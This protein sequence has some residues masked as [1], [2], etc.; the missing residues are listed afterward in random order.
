MLIGRSFIQPR[1][2]WLLRQLWCPLTHQLRFVMENN[3]VIWLFREYLATFK[4]TVAMHEV[5]LQRIA[6]HSKLRDDVNFRVFLEYTEDVSLFYWCQTTCI[7]NV[8]KPGHVHIYK[9]CIFG[10]ML[11]SWFSAKGK[12]VKKLVNFQYLVSI[13]IFYCHFNYV[14]IVQLLVYFF[15][16][17]QILC[18]ELGLELVAYLSG[19]PDPSS[20]LVVYLTQVV[21]W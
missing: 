20:E 1:D 6:V 7:V 3:C 8:S 4:K 21:N 17:K 14:V 16:R 5:F 18:Y 19:V 11:Q 15:N 12:D 10:V 13:E 9:R 2:G